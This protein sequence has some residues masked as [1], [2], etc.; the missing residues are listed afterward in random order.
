MDRKDLLIDVSENL[1]R[2]IDRD[3]NDF[4]YEIRK[5]E[6]PIIRNDGYSEW[7][8]HLVS[9]TWID[10]KTLYELAVTI[11]IL[12]PDN[13]I[14]WYKTFFVVEKKNYLEFAGDVLLPEG[15]STFDNVINKIKFGRDQSNI[16]TNE[17]IDEI[18]KQKLNEYDLSYHRD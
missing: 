14:D 12:F 11:S 13:K 15:T 6:L 16:D 18:V 1:V 9:K 10:I 3:N 7:I 5:Q 4:V 8:M 2:L 17:I